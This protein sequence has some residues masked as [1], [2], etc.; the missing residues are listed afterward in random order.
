MRAAQ[1][2]ES[3]QLKAHRNGGPGRRSRSGSG[4]WVFFNRYPS[5]WVPAAPASGAQV[6]TRAATME[7]WRTS[8]PRH[9]YRIEDWSRL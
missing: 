3:A 5:E 8:T 7:F 6:A 2:R 1:A 4:A 9:K